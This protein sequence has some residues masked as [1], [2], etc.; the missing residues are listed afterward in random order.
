MTGNQAINQTNTSFLLRAKGFWDL[1][2]P[3][4]VL[5][6]ALSIGIGA[7]VTGTLSPVKNVLLACLSGGV[8]TGAANAINDYFDIEIDLINKPE[9]PLPAGRVSPPGAFAWSITLFLLGF[10]L[11]FFINTSAIAISGTASLLLF[12][13]SWRFKRLPLIGNFTVSF[14]SGLAFIYGGVAVGRF[15][16]SII[17]ATFAF[18][19][20]FGREII[21]DIE[22]ISGDRAE[23]ARTFPICCGVNLARMLISFIFFLLIIATIIPYFYD[24]YNVWYFI[25]VLFGV[26]FYIVYVVWA[27]WKSID[28]DHLHKLS[29]GLKI[30]MLVGLLSILVGIQ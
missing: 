11:S 19:F 21:K 18:L 4:N 6:G 7:W 15:Q 28:P 26:D 22:D 1:L 12:L 5:I 8:I 17:P 14:I 24:I 29:T 10:G 16:A 30:D 25:I 23:K 3:V 13:Y 9:R 2:R 27:L 20:H